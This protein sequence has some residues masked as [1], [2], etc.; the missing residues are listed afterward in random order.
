M[1]AWQR[2]VENWLDG[3]AAESEVGL[4]DRSSRPHHCPGQTAPD[5]EAEVVAARQAERRGHDQIAAS[6]AWLSAPSRTSWARHHVPHLG[7]LD[8][9]AGEVIRAAPAATE[10][11]ER[12]RPGELAHM[13]VGRLGRI[14]TAAGGRRWGCGAGDDRNRQHGGSYDHL[15]SPVVRRA[16]HPPGLH[17]AA[18]PC[19]TTLDGTIE[20]SAA[21]TRPADS[22]Q[23]PDPVRLACGGRRRAGR[24]SCGAGSRLPQWARDRAHRVARGTR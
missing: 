6:S 19:T 2:C 21:C 24:F 12:A 18:L 8:P 14:P 7:V 10:R 15:R 4:P 9:M 16:R 13:D 22:D 1:S 5:V 23:R 20:P 11:Y 3:L 17:R